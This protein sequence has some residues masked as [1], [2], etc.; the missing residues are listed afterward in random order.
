MR[1]P[2]YITIEEQT[3]HSDL[4]GIAAL[5]LEEFDCSNTELVLV[6]DNTYYIVFHLI[7]TELEEIKEVASTITYILISE[8]IYR[9]TLNINTDD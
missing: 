1:Q 8:E 3:Y 2:A 4:K 9:F 5:I 6:E 7:Y